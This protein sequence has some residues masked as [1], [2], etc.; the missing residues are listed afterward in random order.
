M[1]VQQQQQQQHHFLDRVF[2]HL[3][4]FFSSASRIKSQF[5]QNFKLKC[6]ETNKLASKVYVT[7]SIYLENKVKKKI[8][9]IL[10][11]AENVH[12]FCI[13]YTHM[14]SVSVDAV[15]KSF[16]Q[17]KKSLTCLLAC[18][19]SNFAN[20]WKLQRKFIFKYIETIRHRN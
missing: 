13:L 20:M 2:H 14:R 16:R 9:F 4:L 11:F 17:K 6:I 8:Y 3:L 15:L 5:Q 7:S 1:F 19:C 12:T 10:C 18:V